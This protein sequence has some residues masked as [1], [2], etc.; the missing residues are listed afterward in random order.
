MIRLIIHGI[1]NK[2]DALAAARLGIDGLG[3]ILDESSD[4]YIEYTLAQNIIHELPPGVAVFLQP[5]RLDTDYLGELVRKLRVSSLILPVDE[6]APVHESLGCRLTLRGDG[7]SIL[8]HANASGQS[9]QYLPEDLSLAQ[10]RELSPENRHSW[11]D[12]VN[13]HHLLVSCGLPP[14]ELTSALD[15]F[16][17]AALFFRGETE[18]HSGLQDFPT[19]QAYIRAKAARI[20][21]V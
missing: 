7:Q 3:F 14:E 19:I 9:R 8:R 12:V 15:K 13:A 20:E 10:I 4:R 21:R 16:T 2:T 6:V 18:D 17:P 11:L 1:T 5:D